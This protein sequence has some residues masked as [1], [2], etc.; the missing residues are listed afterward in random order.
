MK[1]DYYLK[2]FFAALIDLLIIA[3]AMFVYTRI[4]DGELNFEE[5]VI[6]TVIFIPFF[7]MYFIFSEIMFKTT[8]G[9]SIFSLKIKSEN[10][11]NVLRIIVRNVFNFVEIVIPPLYIMTVIITGLVGNKK[12]M[13]L[14]DLLSGC[15]V[16]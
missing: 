10:K 3:F 6:P 12:P 4:N 9:K 7:Y 16:E 15:Y 8:I 2:R 13:K 14:G 5:K 1:L 11:M